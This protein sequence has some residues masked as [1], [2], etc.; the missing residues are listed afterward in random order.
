MIKLSHIMDIAAI[1]SA[2]CVWSLSFLNHMSFKMLFCF[3]FL[4]FNSASD[5]N[6][7]NDVNQKQ[8]SFCFI[9]IIKKLKYYISF[10]YN[11]D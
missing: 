6:M 9:Y 2:L 8:A 4:Y 7:I 1:L 10:K 11:V 3:L 5:L